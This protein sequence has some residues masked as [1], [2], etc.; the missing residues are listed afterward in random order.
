MSKNIDETQDTIYNVN[1]E[2]SMKIGNT[3]DYLDIDTRKKGLIK[4]LII[5]VKIVYD[6]AKKK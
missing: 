5:N 3:L 1:T 6:E 2:Q 4:K